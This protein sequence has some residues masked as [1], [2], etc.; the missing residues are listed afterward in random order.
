MIAVAL[1]SPVVKLE[2]EFDSP[3][4]KIEVDD[5]VALATLAV[6]LVAVALLNHVRG[7]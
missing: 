2:V 4:A 7:G 6:A 1:E 5:V 3:V